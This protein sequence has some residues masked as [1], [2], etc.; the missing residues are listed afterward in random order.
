[1]EGI[2]PR[3]LVVAHRDLN[4]PI[5]D[6]ALRIVRT[7]R[8]GVRRDRLGLA[9][10]ARMDVGG[11]DAS[12][13]GE[14]FRNSGGAS[15]RQRLIIRVGT[16]T[17]G[18]TLDRH[19]GIRI[20]FQETQLNNPSRCAFRNALN[21]RAISFGLWCT[22]VIAANLRLALLLLHNAG[23]VLTA[24]WGSHPDLCMAIV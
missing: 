17:V 7:I 22:A 11:I 20:R 2:I 14:P 18:M 10:T 21:E 4:A 9:P 24:S 19:L 3:R 23:L 1:V 13:D 12:I 8:I 5:L 15:L 16:F 6:A